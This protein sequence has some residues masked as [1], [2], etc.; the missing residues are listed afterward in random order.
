MS[1]LTRLVSDNFRSLEKFQ[2]G[3]PSPPA[4]SKEKILHGVWVVVHNYPHVRFDLNSSIN[5]RDMNG[6]RKV[7]CQKK[8]WGG[9]IGFY[10]YDF[11]LVINCTRGRI[12][13]RFCN[14]AFDS[15]TS[16]YLAITLAFNPRRRDSSGMI[17]VKFCMEVSGWLGYKWRR[18]I[19]AENFNRLSRVHERYRRQKSERRICD[20]KYPN[21]T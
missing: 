16:L 14:I 21:V 18:N 9:T 12:V 19:I 15:P 20:S 2:L 3:A 17:S 5:V 10:V 7:G 1:F 4:T 11:L 6:F 13:H 8:L